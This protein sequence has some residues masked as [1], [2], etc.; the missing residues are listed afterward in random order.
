MFLRRPEELDP[1]EQEAR[2]LL[3][4]L[5]PTVAKAEPLVR[6]FLQMV[7]ERRGV[8]LDAWLADALASG[9]MELRNFAKGVQR[10]YAAVRE[11]LT[12][13]VSQ[14]QVEGQV[15]RLKLLKRSMYGRATFDLLRK[16]VLYRT[17][18]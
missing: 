9:V 5:S 1:Q 12:T 3:I 2:E 14:G 15:N 6:Q 13:S 17:G 16:R 7:R 10:D 8:D 4:A 18:G 11:G